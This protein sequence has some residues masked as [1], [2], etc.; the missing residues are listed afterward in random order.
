MT[1]TNWRLRPA[2]DRDRPIVAAMLGDAELP[3]DGLEDHF[4]GGY[5]VAEQGG[6]IVAAGG[7][8]VY[9][10]YGLLRSVVVRER[11][12]GQGLGE[13]IVE[14]RLRW[15]AAKGLR[16]VYLLTTTVPKFF[17]HVGFRELSR[18]EMPSE[19]QGS[20]EFSEVCPTSATAMVL[21]LDP[22]C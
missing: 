17:E 22:I 15:S 14:N 16:A 18:S 4:A 1:E 9:G 20:K 3:V 6:D 19:I 5:V 2:E 7:I 21:R 12:R 13:T 11:A 8:E 10:Y